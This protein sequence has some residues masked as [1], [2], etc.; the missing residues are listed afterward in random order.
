MKRFEIFVTGTIVFCGIIAICLLSGCNA[1][2]TVNQS[3]V[4]AINS[5]VTVLCQ[6]DSTVPGQ[7]AVAQAVTTA[8]SP[9]D[10]SVVAGLSQA[11][12]LI[13]PAVIA[14][15]KALNGMPASVS[16]TPSP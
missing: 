5:T 14:A 16:V 6:V 3:V 8:L 1:D 7:L 9:S 12:Q 4:S 2:G 11:D 10:A 15:C 13:H